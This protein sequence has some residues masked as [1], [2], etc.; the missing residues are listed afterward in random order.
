LEYPILSLH[1]FSRKGISLVL[2]FI[3]KH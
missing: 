2:Y 1:L 3:Q